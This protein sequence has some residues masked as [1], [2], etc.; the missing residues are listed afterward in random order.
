MPNVV[1]LPSHS[2]TSSSVHSNSRLDVSRQNPALDSAHTAGI[3]HSYSAYPYSASTIPPHPRDDDSSDIPTSNAEGDF[4]SSQLFVTYAPSDR[5]RRSRNTLHE[6]VRLFFSL[7]WD[8]DVRYTLIAH[9]FTIPQTGSP[10]HRP[11]SPRETRTRAPRLVDDGW[12]EQREAVA[13]R[14]RTFS[15]GAATTRPKLDVRAERLTSSENG[16][17]SRGPRVRFYPLPLHSSR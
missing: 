12:L 13:P 2:S 1:N 16:E 8:D 9:F 3:V 11:P 10:S 6:P 17:T 14:K 15:S 7:P 5:T 4:S